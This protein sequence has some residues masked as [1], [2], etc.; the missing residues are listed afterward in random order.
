[1]AE[2]DELIRKVIGT[3]RKEK[4]VFEQIQWLNEQLDRLGITPKNDD[5]NVRRVIGK[6]RSVAS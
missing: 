4:S 1:M 3:P 6:P 2:H 5:R